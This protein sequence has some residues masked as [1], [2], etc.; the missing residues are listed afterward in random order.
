MGE[1]RI[2]RKKIAQIYFNLL[3]FI[4]GFVIIT[5]DNKLY[6]KFIY[7]V[8]I[9][10]AISFIFEFLFF[11]KRTIYFNIF[12][13][14][15]LFFTILAISSTFWSSDFGYSLGKSLT[16]VLM[17]LN[18][19]MIYNI[20]KIYSN[21]IYLIYGFFLALIVNFIWLLGLIDLELSYEGWR[22]PGTVLQ[23][24][25][26]VFILIS[27]LM[28]VIYLLAR[29]ST[30]FIFKIG[31][32]IIFIIILYLVFFTGS[33]SGLI[34]SLLL[35]ILFIYV[36]S[37]INNIPF[38][39][40]IFFV[41][42][43][44]LNNTSIINLVIENTT[45]EIEYTLNHIV[46][47]F[48]IFASTI[49]SGDSDISSS[50]GHRIYM[51]QN[52]FE[53]WSN[54]PLLGNGIAAFEIKY[55]GYSHNNI[56]ELLVSFGVVGLILFYSLYAYLFSRAVKIENIKLK[57]MFFVFIFIFILFDQSTVSYLNKYKIIA[58]LVI[59]ICMEDTINEKS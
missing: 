6:L 43:L 30:S 23:A 17:F 21:Y 4:Y 39:L 35:I 18:I 2:H 53:M 36:S 34:N 29:D 8:N 16:L 14:I 45:L 40:S 3:F 56:M 44:L 47:R 42:F 58:L 50:T 49:K 31:L 41:G 51:I 33:K 54:S 1:I 52:A 38:F 13:K 25:K 12:F 57:I 26:F 10:I 7:I 19:L 9:S 59:Y 24:N 11:N 22:F 15:Y 32:S 5:C 28:M 48:E 20:N 37:N 46:N 55:I 27:I